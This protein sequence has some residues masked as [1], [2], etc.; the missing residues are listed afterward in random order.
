M[1][2]REW[3][4]QA[5]FGMMIH[6]GLYSLPA[7][8]WRGERMT[9]I[10]E[11]CQQYFRIPNREYHKLAG[12]F[13]PIYFNA[14]EWVKLAKDAGM[15]YMVFTSKHHEGFA[16]Y[17][18]KVSKFN[19]VDATP[20][21]RDVLAELAEACYKHNMKL[22]LYY[23]QELDWSEPN[24]GGYTSGK[25]WCGGRGYWTNNWDFPDDA[26]KNFTQ[27][28][29]DKIKPQVKEI[30]TGY[31]DICLIW[32]DTP[33]VITPEQSEEL[34]RMVKQYQPD[35]LVNSRIGNGRGDYGSAGDNEIP[36]DDK[37]EML[38]ETPA[39]LNDTWGYKSFD[40]NWK[41]A[42]TVKQIKEHLNARGINYLLNVGPDYLGRIPGPAVDI[43][44]EVGKN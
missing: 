2:S 1:T 3:F 15:Q 37:G 36:E 18:S 29:N 7:G 10:G 40:N 25:T 31:G 11:W 9:E 22:G 41:D 27:C 14:E 32:F 17:H 19:I 12:I 42:K 4:K 34:Y 23:S 16:M 24:G 5:K 30:L 20:F 43:L 26:H 13:N 38:F 33:G 39:T 35:C 6:W 44:R 21:G 28:F 8:E